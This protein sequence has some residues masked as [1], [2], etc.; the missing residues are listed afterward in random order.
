MYA[1]ERGEEEEEKRRREDFIGARGNSYGSFRCAAS[2][3]THRCAR[4]VLKIWNAGC[5]VVLHSVERECGQRKFCEIEGV[6]CKPAMGRT[7]LLY[8][9]PN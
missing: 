3:Y 6:L 9:T 1:R 7:L 5:M 8:T 4:A 2:M